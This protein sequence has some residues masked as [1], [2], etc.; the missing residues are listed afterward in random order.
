M[1]IKQFIGAAML[2]ALFALVIRALV[3]EQGWRKTFLEIGTLLGAIATFM[4]GTYL[5]LV[6][7]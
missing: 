5:L 4:A 3:K 6:S 2:L 1:T 7:P